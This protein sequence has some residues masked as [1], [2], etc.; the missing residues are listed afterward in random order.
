MDEDINNKMMCEEHERMEREA[1]VFTR[2]CG[3]LALVISI[4]V[5]VILLFIKLVRL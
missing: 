3:M 1:K 4:V 2:G 5:G